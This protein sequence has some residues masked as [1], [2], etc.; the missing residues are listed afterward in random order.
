MHFLIEL[1]HWLSSA[2]NANTD[3]GGTQGNLASVLTWNASLLPPSAL[4]TKGWEIFWPSVGVAALS[5]QSH[6]GF[7]FTCSQPQP[8]ATLISL[9]AFRNGRLTP[10]L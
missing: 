4:S 8:S 3:G 2:E 9:T 6:S 5:S 7:P 10:A 1:F